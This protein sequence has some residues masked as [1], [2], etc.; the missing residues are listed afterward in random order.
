[1]AA[2]MTPKMVRR[3]PASEKL[4]SP[5]VVMVAPMIKGTRERYVIVLYVR[6][7]HTRK[8]TMAKMGVSMR[9]VW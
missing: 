2:R 7:Y 6:P 3:N 9:I 8:M 4:I 1:M 5:A